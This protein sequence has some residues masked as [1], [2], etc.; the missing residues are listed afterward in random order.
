[1]LKMQ[2]AGLFL[3]VVTSACFNDVPSEE[4]ATTEQSI[5]WA[6]DGTNTWIRRWYH[7][8]V[9]QG[10]ED[11]YCDGTVIQYG[12]I[13]GTYQQQWL[14]S[15]RAGGGGGGGGGSGCLAHEPALG[16][17]TALYPPPTCD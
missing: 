9:E 3:V 2:L 6:C 17:L 12:Q 4:T 13:G 15:C 10:R 8:G 5:L 11:C 1:M 7:N 14:S 16:V